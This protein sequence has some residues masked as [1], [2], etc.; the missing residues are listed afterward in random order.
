MECY[1]SYPAPNP[2][3][4][5]PC[6]ITVPAGQQ[7]EIYGINFSITTSSTAAS[8]TAFLTARDSY[9]NIMLQA[10]AAYAS[11]ASQICVISFGPGENSL[12]STVDYVYLT[13]KMGRIIIGPGATLTVNFINLQSGDQISG[14]TAMIKIVQRF[15][16]LPTTPGGWTCP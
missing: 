16:I 9:G 4:G 15:T 2:S 1:S 7:W 8:R 14:I 5:Q 11:A 3:T 10:F 6:V 13:A 12:T